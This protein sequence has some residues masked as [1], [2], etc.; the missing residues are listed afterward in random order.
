M[1]T[2]AREQPRRGDAASPAT[3]V[4]A[5]ALLLCIASALL[6]AVA[7]GLLR[8][9]VPLARA[10]APDWLGQAALQ[11]A[12]LMIC[13]FMGTVIAVERAVAVK[14]ALAW[15][16]PAASALAGPALL[17]GQPALG[18]A[19]LVLSGAAFVAVNVVVVQR[20]SEP[21]T[22][23]LLASAAAWLAG[24]A[25]FAAGFAPA[26]VV[27]WWFA[28][29]VMTIAAERLEMTRLMRRR[30]GALPALVGLLAL[31]AAAS[32]WSAFDPV[33]GGLLYGAALLGLAVWLLAFDIARR[34]LF[35]QGLSRYM[36]VCLLG[37]YGWLAVGGLAWAATALG[38][39]ARDTALHA[40]G[41]GFVF[42]MMM[43]HAPV[44]L[45]AVA[46]VKLLFGWPFYL[47]LALLHGSLLMR[48]GL[49]AVDA[50]WL[51]RGAELNAA[52][53]ALF[54][55]TAIGAVLAWNRKD[56]LQ[57]RRPR[58]SRRSESSRPG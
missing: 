44:I 55:L 42:S 12:A 29:L 25:L 1:R 13:A 18:G 30:R 35:T 6:S 39:P 54:A 49:R 50:G 23:L 37:G 22:W 11:H 20:Q 2:P 38:A 47:P 45:P 17:L 36:A 40:L 53:I 24:N 43:G 58:A 31:L 16:A 21:H 14:L 9:G 3:R 33:I 15:L 5:V 10:G 48:L 8:A 51:P 56:A 34:T 57:A 28:F 19:L 26:A 52:A 41:L 32:A 27:P 4:L 7:G 46:R